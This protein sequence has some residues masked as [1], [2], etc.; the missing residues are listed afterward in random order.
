MVQDAEIN[1]EKDKLFKEKVEGR[2][3]LESYLYNVKSSTSEDSFQAKLTAEEKTLLTEAVKDG[4]DWLE[5]AS[6]DQSSAEDFE[7]KLKEVEVII[8]PIMTKAYQQSSSPDSQ[9]EGESDDH[10]GSGDDSS[11]TVE[12]VD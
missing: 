12:E 6:M 1:A 2:N 9:S 3:K 8:N 7:E 10:D 11:P 4:L 5:E